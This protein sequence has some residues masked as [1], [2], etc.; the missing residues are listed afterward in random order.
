MTTNH[1]LI[2]G[3]YMIVWNRPDKP[4]RPHTVRVGTLARQN[5]MV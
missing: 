2:D 4:G 3:P 5:R 1:P